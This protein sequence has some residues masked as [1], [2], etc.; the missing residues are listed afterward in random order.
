MKA[1]RDVLILIHNSYD[2]EPIN[3]F[4]EQSDK[5][6][7][8]NCIFL[9]STLAFL[10]NNHSKCVTLCVKRY[11]LQLV[12]SNLKNGNSLNVHRQGTGEINFS[13]TTK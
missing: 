1:R 12:Y 3:L 7:L 4:D 5:I 11:L 2:Y 8:I 13:T 9:G 6:N 10:G